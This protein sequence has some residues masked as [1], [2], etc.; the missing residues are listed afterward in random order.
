MSNQADFLASAGP[1][2]S[3]RAD[4]ARR[5]VNTFLACPWLFDLVIKDGHFVDLLN[6]RIERNLIYLISR[7]LQKG[8]W[9][10]PRII[11]ARIWAEGGAG[12][13]TSPE[14]FLPFDAS[15]KALCDAVERY[16]SAKDAAILD[17]G[18]NVGRHLHDLHARGFSN[19]TGVD[20]MKAAIDRMTS[21]FPETA[22]AAHV[23]HDLFQRFLRRQADR[24][25]DLVY[26][27]GATIELVH[28]S[29]AIVPH[30][31]RIARSH[32]VLILNET[33]H[34]VYPRFW[35]YEFARNGF[36]LREAKR[37]V[38]GIPPRHSSET[39]SLLVYSR[40]RGSH[41]Q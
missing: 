41:H 34:A 4:R 10:W 28:P 9:F 23:H 36:F 26:S 29:F 37:P 6:N 13:S 7:A 3:G 15:S 25:F 24:S 11:D 27:H 19:L 16:A 12:Q 20:A 1:Y 35:T 39:P 18:C 14:S 38:G 30:L 32:V 31:C 21:E 5:F 8:L 22:S 17:L 2:L 40:Y 33:Y